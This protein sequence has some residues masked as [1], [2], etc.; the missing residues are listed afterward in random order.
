MKES[1]SKKGVTIFLC[2][3]IAVLF[4][5]AIVFTII[6]NDLRAKEK[7]YN[8]QNQIINEQIKEN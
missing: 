7:Y 6:K 3:L 8:E 5:L 1:K 4:A 2:I